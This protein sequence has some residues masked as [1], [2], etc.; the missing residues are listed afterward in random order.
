MFAFLKN[1]KIGL[2]I[3]MA[4]SLPAFG[5]LAFSGFAMIDKYQAS[6]EMDKVAELG[7]VPPVISALVHEMQKERGMSAIFISFKGKKFTQQLPPRKTDTNK[8]RATLAETFKAFDAASFGAIIVG[9]IETAQNALKALDNKRTQITGLDITVPQMAKYYT[10]TITKLL[11][12]VEA[13]AQLSSNN[14]VSK[15][16][17]AYTY[18]LQSKE[19]SGIERAMG[20]GGFSAGKFSPDVYGKF[21]RLISMQDTYLSRFALYAS[22]DEKAY[23]KPTVSGPVVDEINQLR[24]IAMDSPTTGS[25]QGVTGGH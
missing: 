2:R 10:M 9:T 12:I 22:A 14:E 7:R 8:R 15:I 1:T 18:F 25:T 21:V 17:A 11:G 23:L 20:A 19:R 5:V 3:V 24:K 16:I 4:L 13:I 6:A